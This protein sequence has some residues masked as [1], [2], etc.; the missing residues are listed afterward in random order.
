MEVS[1]QLQSPAAL[2]PGKQPTG[3]IGQE[4]GRAPDGGC[5]EEKIEC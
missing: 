5:R 3:P 1:G 4:T 2:P